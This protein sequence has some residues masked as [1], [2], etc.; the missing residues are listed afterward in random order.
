MTVIIDDALMLDTELSLTLGKRT[1][2][3][4]EPGQVLLRL[5]WAGVCG[6][7]LHVLRT[8]DWVSAWPA[9]LGH[10][11]VGVVEECPGNELAVGSR[12]VLDSRMPC[13]TCE[14]CR[15]AKN[16][17]ERMRWLGEGMPGGFQRRAV[18]AV[19]QVV[20]CPEE[21]EPALAVLGE[22]LA[23][24][25]HAV[26][27]AGVLPD[28]VLILGYGPVGALVHAEIIRRNPDALVSVIE[29]LASR[30]LMARAAG[31]EV[32]VETTDMTWPLVVDAAGH[33]SSLSEGVHLLETGGVL[34]L[35]GLAHHPATIVPQ[36]LTER[37]LTVIGSNGFVDELPQALRMLTSRPDSYRWL[38]TD[39]ISLEEAP[40][41][42]SVM[43]QVPV[44]GKLVIAL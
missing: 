42:L 18:F 28:R 16:L 37:S 4:P 29:P 20:M 34:L 12:V 8:G 19:D 13:G 23:V 43:S 33:S 38:I 25:M 3:H 10:E 17:C 41:R 24:A 11:V 26:T 2:N 27:R 44:A 21:L 32:M 14:G 30:T 6:S 22:P 35:V 36:D 7:D 5:E 1:M 15:R 39:S 9:T 40:R 31:A